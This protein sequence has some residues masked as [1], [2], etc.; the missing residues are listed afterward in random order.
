MRTRERTLLVMLGLVMLAARVAYV[1]VVPD[2]DTDAY[3]HFH[4]GRALVDDPS[5]VR[6]HWVWLPGWHYVLMSL[7]R[8]GIGFTGVRLAQ[9]A[10]ATLGPL[11]VYVHAAPKS[12]FAAASLFTIA[13]LP[14]LAGTSALM[15]VVFTLLVLA[16]AIAI[17]RIAIDGRREKRWA[18]A[19]GLLL[20]AAASL[21]YE[22]WFIVLGLGVELAIVTAR[23]VLLARRSGGAPPLSC[24]GPRVIVFALPALCLAAYIVFRRV[25]DGEWLWFVRETYRFTHMQRGYTQGDHSALFDLVWFPILLPLMVLGPAAVLVVAGVVLRRND[26]SCVRARSAIV[27]A[28]LLLFLLLSYMGKGALGQARY[29]TV[30]IPFA[31]VAIAGALARMKPPLQRWLV[32]ATFASV[33]GATLFVGQRNARS[34][35]ARKSELRGL[36]EWARTP[37]TGS[38]ASS[39]PP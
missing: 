4:I 2:L 20:V 18:L 24:D 13:A 12:R 26:P 16:A 5:D 33:A 25:V 28:S 36:E 30:L 21:R 22:A 15:E 11:L 35:L 9:A 1:L 39:P 17:D 3:G 14:N 27:P 32:V 7:Q 19:A 6:V 31:C 8:A 34:A 29:L 23:R 37:T 10:L 38:R